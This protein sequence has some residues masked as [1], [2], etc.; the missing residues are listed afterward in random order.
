[1]TFKEKYSIIP[2]YIV[3]NTKRRSGQLI[4]PAVK[5]I[6]AHDTGNPQSTALNNVNYFKRS[7]KEQEASAHI[8]VDDKQIL[9]CV[10]ALTGKPEKAWHVLY[11]LPT[12]NKMF[13]YNANDTAIGVEYCYGTNINANEAYKKYVWVLAYICYVF[14]LDPARSI[15]GHHILNPGRKS[16]PVSGLK[17]SGRTYEK[18]LIDVVAEYKDCLK[19]VEVEN[20]A[21]NRSGRV[22]T[23]SAVKLRVGQ[24]NTLEY[25]DWTD[26][27]EIVSG[28]SKWFRDKDG[29]FFWSGATT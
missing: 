8:F 2:D 22:K 5:F 16:D 19:Q 21:I 23:T 12:D 7:A 28:I 3:P 27:G 13:G 11:N 20:I 10:P 1:M 26:K 9:E 6:V 29:N 15:V 25:V 18:L 4:F 14:K 24:P 17:A